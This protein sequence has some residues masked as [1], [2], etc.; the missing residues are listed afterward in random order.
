MHSE[1]TREQFRRELERGIA[2]DA[3]A[4]NLAV[5]RTTVFRWRREMQLP[6]RTR[7]TGAPC[8]R[9]KAEK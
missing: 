2:F 9:R 5:G 8:H 3:I 1:F 6:R 4:K 7:G